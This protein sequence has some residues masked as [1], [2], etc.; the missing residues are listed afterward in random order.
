[1][2]DEPDGF[3]VTCLIVYSVSPGAVDSMILRD[4]WGLSKRRLDWAGAGQDGTTVAKLAIVPEQTIEAFLV[5]LMSQNISP[6][7]RVG[8]IDAPQRYPRSFSEA[9]SARRPGQ[10][11]SRGVWIEGLEWLFYVCRRA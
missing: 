8:F 6:G 10:A 4:P 7:R 5:D 11:D 3:P 2:F 9:R 1:M